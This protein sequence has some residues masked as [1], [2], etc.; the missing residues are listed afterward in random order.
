MRTV[1]IVDGYNAIFAI[2]ST[3]EL[4]S[5]S[6]QKAR[7]RLDRLCRDYVRSSGYI[8]IFRIVFDGVKEQSQDNASG[9]LLDKDMIFSGSKGADLLLIET[10]REYSQAWRVIAAS[11]DNYVRNN[12]RALGAELIFPS[13]LFKKE[14]SGPLDGKL[15][16]SREQK[17]EI[18][19]EYRKRLGF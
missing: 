16:L 14:K 5:S 4:M 18:T 15:S 8:D 17:S 9:E 11:G 7:R 1:L 2:R 6:M 13:D 3:K 19:R 10:V 12:C